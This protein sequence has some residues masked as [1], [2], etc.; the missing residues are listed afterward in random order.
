MNPP[1]RER[2]EAEV[3]ALELADTE[4]V[5]HLLQADLTGVGV[6]RAAVE[7][8]TQ[9]RSPEEVRLRQEALARQARAQALRTQAEE[10]RTDPRNVASLSTGELLRRLVRR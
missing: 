5:E 4:L 2:F 8:A 3:R 1:L 6:I 7:F 9:E 10:L